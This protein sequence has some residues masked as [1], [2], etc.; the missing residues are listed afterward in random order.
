MNHLTQPD[1]PTCPQ[2]KPVMTTSDNPSPLLAL[3]T[4]RELKRHPG[5]KAYKLT[6]NDSKCVIGAEQPA[7]GN[8]FFLS[9][10]KIMSGGGLESLYNELR[11]HSCV[12]SATV[13][14]GS[15]C[16]VRWMA[17]CLTTKGDQIKGDFLVSAA[18]PHSF[19]YS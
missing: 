5:Q 3:E 15:G 14:V 17:L 10:Y 18:P 16:S 19:G 9:I 2:E 1:S 4:D 13:I 11:A 8:F 12:R 7:A 6:R